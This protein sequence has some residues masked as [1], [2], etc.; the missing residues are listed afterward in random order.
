MNWTQVLFLFFVNV[1]LVLWFRAESRAN[2]RR[3]DNKL[4]I[5]M[6]GMQEEQI[7]H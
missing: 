4:D 3:M 1:G 2:W 6:K 5:F 7:N